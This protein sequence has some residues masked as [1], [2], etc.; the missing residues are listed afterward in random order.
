VRDFLNLGYRIHDTDRFL[1]DRFKTTISNYGLSCP[2][3]IEYTTVLPL[4]SS[5]KTDSMRIMG[6]SATTQLYA[7]YK[8]TSYTNL[9]CA[10]SRALLHL[11]ATSA[12]MLGYQT[13]RCLFRQTPCR[14]LTIVFLASIKKEHGHFKS[15]LCPGVRFTLH[16]EPLNGSVTT[17]AKQ[18][19]ISCCLI[20]C[21]SGVTSNFNR[22]QET[23]QHQWD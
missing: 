2:K 6:V 21:T 22:S 7:K 10:V 19:T 1:R 5:R 15:S 16:Q 20:T 13:R 3:C 17:E 4:P 23:C 14:P 18:S 8:L 11:G 12:H 9:Q